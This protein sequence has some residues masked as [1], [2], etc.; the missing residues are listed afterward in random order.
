[1]VSLA[2]EGGIISSRMDRMEIF[3]RGLAYCI[4]V[5]RAKG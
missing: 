5:Q 1:M 2:N 3:I 4:Q